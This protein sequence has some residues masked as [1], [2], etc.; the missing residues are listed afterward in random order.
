MEL[1]FTLTQPKPAHP[2]ISQMVTLPPRPSAT[3]LQDKAATT[4]TTGNQ[5]GDVGGGAEKEEGD[6]AKAAAMPVV[7]SHTSVH[8]AI[9]HN[10]ISFDT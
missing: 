8:D 7:P 10:L 9:D 3:S 6:D 2:V 5:D 4:T 1:P